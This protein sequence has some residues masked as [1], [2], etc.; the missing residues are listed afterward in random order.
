MR[1]S[2]S[3]LSCIKTELNAVSDYTYTCMLLRKVT[4]VSHQNLRLPLME[5]GVI[6]AQMF[7][8]FHTVPLHT[9]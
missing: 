6:C 1:K 7:A 5:T 4:V 3:D 9:P 2:K 8:F